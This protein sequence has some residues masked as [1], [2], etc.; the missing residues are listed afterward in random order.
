MN[1]YY[2]HVYMSE[3]GKHIQ[4][5]GSY[6]SRYDAARELDVESY[7]TCITNSRLYY[8]H[9][10]AFENGKFS[11]IDMTREAEEVAAREAKDLASYEAD[12]SSLRSWYSSTRL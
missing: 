1:N 12:Q 11:A 10:I 3:D 2:I 7:T 5:E 9:T 8:Y 4:S 6:T